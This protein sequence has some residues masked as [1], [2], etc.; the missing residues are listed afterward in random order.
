VGRYDLHEHHLELLRRLC[1]ASDR[2][3][4]ARAV[5]EEH[6]LVYANRFGEPRPRP[7]VAIE[8]DSRLAVVRITRE[9]GLD[10][11]PVPPREPGM[12]Y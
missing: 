7:E 8:R 10:V 11:E 2:A 5:L 9:L 3:D 1:E 12:S 6:G 4:A